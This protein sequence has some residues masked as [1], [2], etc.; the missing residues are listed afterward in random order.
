MPQLSIF[1]NMNIPRLLLA[2]ICFLAPFAFADE[3][4]TPSS[5]WAEFQAEPDAFRQKHSG[6]KITIS[7]IVADTHI[8]IYLTPVVSL[9]DKSG[10]EVKVICVLPRTEAGKL[11]SFKQGAK[12]KMTGNFYAAR[13]EKIV[14]KQCQGM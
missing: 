13:E 4:T 5:L 9:V 8:S 10:D 12:V 1:L 2:A 11:S 3:A 6:G 7:A 14:I